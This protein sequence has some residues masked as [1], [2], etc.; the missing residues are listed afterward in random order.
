MDFF[1][2]L[3]LTISLPLLISFVVSKFLSSRGPTDQELAPFGFDFGFGSRIRNL[4]IGKPSVVVEDFVGEDEI[5]E[6]EPK[7]GNFTGVLESTDGTERECDD[8]VIESV[9]ILEERVESNF[10]NTGGDC[11]GEGAE[12]LIDESSV[13]MRCEE[14][15]IN[16]DEEEDVREGNEVEAFESDRSKESG[17]VSEGRSV[18]EIA[19]E[20]DDW[21]GV[22]RTELEKLFEDAVGIVNYREFEDP[23]FSGE[24]KMR[25]NGLYKI[26]MEGP[27]REP[28]PMAL[29]ISA[30]AKWNAWKQLGNMTPEMAMESYLHLVAENIPGWTS[31]ITSES[32]DQNASHSCK[33]E[34]LASETKPL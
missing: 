26:A 4:E 20:D 17:R 28:P 13:R 3:A 1:L 11:G 33:S 14:T 32:S 24:L 18:E 34:K 23:K 29:K 2:E 10:D 19:V 6:C 21:E 25:L 9:G 5:V 12:K 7:Q 27:C 8:E 31:E 22:E 16:R 15:G 30:R